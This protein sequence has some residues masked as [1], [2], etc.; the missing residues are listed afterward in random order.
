MTCATIK[1][2]MVLAVLVLSAMAGL[3]R[4]WLLAASGVVLA[5]ALAAVLPTRKLAGNRVR[6]HRL[7]IRLRLH[8]G[9]GHAT[10]FGLWLR[11][12]R[13]AS[14]RQSRRARP[15]LSA[16]ER[17]AHPQEHS[18]YIGRAHYGHGVRVPVQEHAAVL[19]PPREGKS[20]WL[21]KVIMHY[22]G[23][24]VSTSSKPD[25]FMLTSGIRA[26]CGPVHVF[27]PQGLGGVPSTFRWSPI[28]GCRDEATAI[29][30]ADAFAQAVSVRGTEDSS[31]WATKA[32][33][34][35][36]ALFCAGDIV[37]A[38]MRLVSRWILGQRTAE[39][40]DILAKAG[41]DQWAATLAELL[42]PAEKTTATVRMVMSSSVAFMTD[43]KLA[44][45]VLPAD[46]AGFDIDEFLLAS[47]TLYMV[48]K[49]NGAD[50]PLAPLFSAMACEI[51]YRATELGSQMPGGRLDPP[52][53]L[54]LD[55]VTQI[56]PV[57]LPAWL[58]DSGGQGVQI[59]PVAHGIAQ[60]RNR[61]KETGARIILDTCT[62]KVFLPGL[63]D[64][65]T[66]S[67]ASRLC[68]TVA[69][70]EGGQQHYTRHAVISDEMIRQLPRNR[71]LIVRGAEAPVIV[72]LGMGWKDRA[73]KTARRAG[74]AVA[75]LQPAAPPRALDLESLSPI[76]PDDLITELEEAAGAPAEPVPAAADNPWG[77]R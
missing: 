14:F 5:L 73:Y 55:E 66:L 35:L 41:H 50:S 16:R 32:S 15:S 29:R 4:G 56:C 53:L 33:D 2:R 59:L 46:G 69:F 68:G 28:A 24:V 48:A 6:V 75:A 43:P 57:P 40:I 51:Q 37:G 72:S 70:R 8:P 3:F 13:F 27:S 44:E 76:L 31:F 34:Y 30:R 49:S 71:A 74:T 60:L 1:T 10:V 25:Q 58:A 63:S 47:G 20:G 77:V 9:R 62:S 21:A 61:W 64:P 54:A 11:W 22:P 67:M 18:V 19:G 7:R 45:S 52:L 23:S 12:G 26:A 36:R 38:D 42:G 39:A 65:D 17:L